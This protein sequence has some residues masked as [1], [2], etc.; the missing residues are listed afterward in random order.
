MSS[1]RGLAEFGAHVH[2]FDGG[3]RAVHDAGEHLDARVAAAFAI[4]PA[5]ERRRGGAEHDDGLVEFGAHHSDVA[6]VVA[7]R[8]L[9]LVAAVVL[10]VDE[11]EAE[12]DHRRKDSGAR[13]DDDAGFAATNAMPLLGALV[14]RKAGVQQRDLR[15][16]GGEH[17]ARH[18]GREA[19]LRDQQK[20]GLA[21][22]QRALHGGEVDGGLARA[23]DA[24]EKHWSKS[25][26][27]HGAAMDESASICA[28][29][30]ACS[31]AFFLPSAGRPPR[32]KSS[33]TSSIAT[34]PR[35]TSVASVEEGTPSSRSA[36]DSRRS[37]T[38]MRPPAAAISARIAVWFSFSLG[39]RASGTSTA[40][41]SVRRAS[42]SSARASRVS[43]F[44]F[45]MPSSSAL[46]AFVAERT[47]E[48]LAALPSAR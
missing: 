23:G 22:V 30:S 26:L 38:R 3:Q 47:A 46:L 19:D 15:S 37:T 7:R 13:A 45:T 35:L 28:S 18:R 42:R 29:F 39:M 16:E 9:L 48:A 14:G 10:L 12:V 31:C 27:R 17:L 36:N 1:R 34:R 24:V 5:L 25:A 6:G 32:W 44:F 21:R 41:R 43:H 33:G 2:Q 40:M 20:R 8:L 11:D 4:G